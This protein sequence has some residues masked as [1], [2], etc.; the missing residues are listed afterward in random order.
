MGP[1]L[2]KS[3][4]TLFQNFDVDLNDNNGV[5]WWWWHHWTLSIDD[6]DNDDG[7]ED[8]GDED[9]DDCDTVTVTAAQVLG[10]ILGES[11]AFS[12]ICPTIN[13][14]SSV[15]T[16]IL[17]LHFQALLEQSKILF[18]FTFYSALIEKIYKRCSKL[19]F[20]QDFFWDTLYTKEVTKQINLE[21]GDWMKS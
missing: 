3:I 15:S 4:L 16:N 14:P 21:A 18:T 19:K 12:V 9:D 13:S 5:V 10:F 2:S 11:T 6:N 7:D 8:G 17:Q 1:P 20:Y